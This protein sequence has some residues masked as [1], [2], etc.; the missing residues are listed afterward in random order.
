VK[1]LLPGAVVLAALVI[2]SPTG[3]RHDVLRASPKNVHMGVHAVGTENLK[4]TRI[5]NTSGED[6]LL[7]VEG[8]RLPDDFGFGLMPGSTCPALGP[9]LL[10]AGESCKAVMNFRPSEFFAGERQWAELTATAYDTAT[11]AVVDT[12]VI[13]FFA[14]GR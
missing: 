13:T 11:G 3:A 12:L 5:K 14:R 2:A 1:R 7:Y 9:A 8:S 4:G 6:V 10:A